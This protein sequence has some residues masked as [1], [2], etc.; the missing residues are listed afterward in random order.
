[1]LNDIDLDIKK[2]LLRKQA[3]FSPLTE[4]EVDVLASLLSEKIFDQPI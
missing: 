3:C 4:D 2:T 1:M